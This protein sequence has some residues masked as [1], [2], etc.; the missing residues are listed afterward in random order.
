MRPS[1][2]APATRAKIRQSLLTSDG[3]WD[4]EWQEVPGPEAIQIAVVQNPELLPL[5]GKR[6]SEVAEL[7]HE[8]PIDALCDLL[9]KDRAFTFVAV[10]GMSE[11]DILLALKQPWVSI[12]NDSQG[13]SP[14]GLLGKEHPTAP[15]RAS[16]VSTFARSTRSHSRTPSASSRRC[17]RSA[18]A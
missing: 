11:P 2:K 4:N 3:S 9:I 18:C 13:T 1:E 17:P 14:L 7:W 16:C 15:F 12:D 5:Q 6:L 8:D 10:F